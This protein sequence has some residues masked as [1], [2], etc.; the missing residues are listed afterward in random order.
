MVDSMCI[1]KSINI[2]IGTEL[3]N[4]EILKLVPDHLKT[5]RLFNHEVKKLP[6][7]L[8]YVPGQY[9][10]QEMCD[11]AILENGGTLNSVPECYKNQEI[12]KMCF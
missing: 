12:N 4:P 3:K 9:K 1:H 10:A 2:N 11:K 5:K 7:L 8:R 6:Y